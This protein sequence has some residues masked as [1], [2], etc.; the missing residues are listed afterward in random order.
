MGVRRLLGVWWLGISLT[1]RRGDIFTMHHFGLIVESF[2]EDVCS[3]F[4]PF[5]A[6]AAE[7]SCYGGKIGI[8]IGREET[9]DQIH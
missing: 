6:S 4:R 9:H 1:G 7:D 3:P 2:R 8:C 5:F